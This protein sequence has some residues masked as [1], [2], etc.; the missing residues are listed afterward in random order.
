M[1]YSPEFGLAFLAGSGQHGYTKPD[2]HY[3]DDLWAYDVNAHRWICLYPG[4]DAKTLRLKRNDHGFETDDRGEPIPVAQLAHGYQNVAYLPEERRFMFVQSDDPYWGKA[5]P[6]RKEWLPPG[7][8]QYGAG[9]SP[10]HPWF[11]DLAR[12]RWER[13]VAEGPGPDT[14]CESVLEYIP[15]R[16]QVFFLYHSGVVWFYD[17]ATRGWT[18]AS[19]SGPPPPFGID[20]VACFDVR[21]NRVYVHRNE[22]LWVYDVARNAWSNPEPTGKPPKGDQGGGHDKTFTFDSA[23]GVA[24][25]TV[26]RD[27][28][29]RKGIYVY[30]PASNSWTKEPH[31][32][33]E[34]ITPRM[35][36]NAFYDPGRNVHVFHAAGDSEDDGVVWAYR[37][38]PAE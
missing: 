37:Y 35:N 15:S 22:V 10:K 3:M 8:S 24:V 27:L 1:A 5:L 30:D 28:P 2:G 4:S 7:A 17:R 33:P 31:P 19:P 16:K 6:Q 38:C 11:W 18:N 25:L 26:Y 14:R 34:S 23:H 21:R 32:F 9:G 12:S 36:L 20:P 29:E 13:D